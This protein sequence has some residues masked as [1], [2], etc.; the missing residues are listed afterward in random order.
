MPNE[1]YVAW[2][3]LLAKNCYFRWLPDYVINYVI[4][5]VDPNYDFQ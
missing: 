3:V 5:Y 4:R 1:W 2:F